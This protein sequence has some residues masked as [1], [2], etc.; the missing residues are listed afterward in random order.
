MKI[1]SNKGKIIA[2]SLLRFIIVVV[3]LVGIYASSR[4]NPNFNIGTFIVMAIFGFA[5][6]A[7]PLR[8]LN[9]VL[10][11]YPNTIVLKRQEI[12]KQEIYF[13]TPKEIEWSYVRGYLIGKRL[14]CCKETKSTGWKELFFPYNEID[15]TYIKNP[16]EEFIRF[17]M[18]TIQGETEHV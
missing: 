14:K 3:F 12:K 9:E 7:S 6:A 10:V 18:N 4:D 13:S 2:V 17:Y 16:Y 11:L 5:F 15:V 8:H 1:S